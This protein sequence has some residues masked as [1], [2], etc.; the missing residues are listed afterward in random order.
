MWWCIVPVTRDQL[1]MSQNFTLSRENYGSHLETAAPPGDEWIQTFWLFVLWQV[2]TLWLDPCAL[3]ELSYLNAGSDQRA[4]WGHSRKRILCQPFVVGWLHF[5]CWTARWRMHH[6]HTRSQ[7]TLLPSIRRQETSLAQ[8][9]RPCGPELDVVISLGPGVSVSLI[10]A[11]TVFQGDGE[12]PSQSR[13]LQLMGRFHTPAS[14][15][16]YVIPEVIPL[17][18]EGFLFRWGLPAFVFISND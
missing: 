9:G 12:S 2:T 10:M 15:L 17:W 6:G 11:I 16:I 3:L 18:L 14:V 1:T 5:L 7:M 8:K 4:G 13:W